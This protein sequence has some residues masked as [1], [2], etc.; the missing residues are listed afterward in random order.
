VFFFAPR[1]PSSD[2]FKNYDKLSGPARGDFTTWGKFTRSGIDG[3]V[4]GVG[5]KIQTGFELIC[6]LGE[7]VNVA[8]SLVRFSPEEL[9]ELRPLVAQIAVSD[10]LDEFF[11][12]N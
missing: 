1:I 8:V 6:I 10:V 9:V 12:I 5:K 2:S 11:N 4:D 3:S 7:D